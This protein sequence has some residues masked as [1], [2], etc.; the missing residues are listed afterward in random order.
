MYKN[1]VRVNK[2]IKWYFSDTESHQDFNL[3]VMEGLMNGGEFKINAKEL[4]D[5][6]GYIPSEICV[7][8]KEDIEYSPSEV[9]LIV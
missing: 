1:K 4:F 9:L 3:L 7:N 6:C 8:Y 5:E 2:F